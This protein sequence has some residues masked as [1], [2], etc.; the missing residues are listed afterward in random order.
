MKS[1]PRY[2]TF[3]LYT[4]LIIWGGCRQTQ[5]G[6]QVVGQVL[7]LD[8]INAPVPYA[9]VDSMINIY[10]E[11]LK[12]EMDQVVVYSAVAMPRGTPEGLLNNFVADLVLDIGQEIYRA[13]NGQG[14]D[15]CLLNYGGLRSS[16]PQG[17]VT[18]ARVFELMPF[19]NE[20]IVLT[21]SPEK[22]MDLFN[23][24]ASSQVGMP[25]SGITLGIAGGEPAR[26]LIQGKPFDASRSYRIITSDY[27]ASGGDNM[28][29][30]LNPIDSELLGMRVRDAILRHMEAK[31]QEGQMISSSLDGRI[32]F[33]D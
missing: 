25:V 32:Y 4:L 1:Y 26:I 16:I 30:F 31:Q 18:R 28:D 33:V 23:Y 15:F 7:L 2:L 29:F 24:L 12:E 14:I 5:Q 8:S 6:I 19:E 20:M 10:R 9:A 13:E 21:L 17:A 27:L 3:L 22:T 11:D